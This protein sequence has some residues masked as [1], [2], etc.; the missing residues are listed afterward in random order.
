MIRPFVLVLLPINFGW[1]FCW[2]RL[3]HQPMNF[4]RSLGLRGYRP[5]KM[6]C[7]ILGAGAGLLFIWSAWRL[8]LSR[9]QVGFDE[10]PLLPVALLFAVG[11]LVADQVHLP[12]PVLF[13][14]SLAWPWPGWF[15]ESFA[16]AAR[17]LI[18]LTG[19]TDVA[20]IQLSLSARFA[21]DTRGHREREN[22]A[23]P[24]PR[25]TR[26]ESI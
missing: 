11:V 9:G 19:W 15:G 23:R 1:R 7:W 10:E 2:R 20:G 22:A 21:G 8:G 18:A 16:A 6:S 13:A 3:W 4:T 14:V 5:S 26:A 25:A 17:F 12:L 24:P